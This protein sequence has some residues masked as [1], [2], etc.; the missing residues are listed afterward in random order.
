MTI[1][2]S[3]AAQGAPYLIVQARDARGIQESVEAV[4]AIGKHVPL[5]GVSVVM[6]PEGLLYTQAMVLR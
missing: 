1:L 6:T 5:G 3:M 2:E 4:M